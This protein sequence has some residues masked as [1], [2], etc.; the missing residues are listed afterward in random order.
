MPDTR[1]S[2]LQHAVLKPGVLEVITEW[3]NHRGFTRR[4]PDDTGLAG[5]TRAVET[6]LE[7]VTPSDVDVCGSTTSKRHSLSFVLSLLAHQPSVSSYA[8]SRQAY[9]GDDSSE[10]FHQ[11]DIALFEN[12]T[13]LASAKGIVVG[14][15]EELGISSSSVAMQTAKW[16]PHLGPAVVVEVPSRGLLSA[17]TGVSA[18][19]AAGFVGLIRPEVW[20]AAEL[21]AE[22]IG[23][24]VS[25]NLE[26]LM[27][28]RS[29]RN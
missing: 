15:A 25:L 11:I 21:D 10:G 1:E 6:V 9:A 13:S 18:R 2:M 5:C 8:L 17:S 29:R 4:Y 20:Q 24:L 19:A 28:S 16:L 22:R 12:S 23:A 26:V 7:R 14:L 3:L 27:Q